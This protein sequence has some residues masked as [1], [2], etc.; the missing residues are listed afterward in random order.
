MYVR[1]VNFLSKLQWH[2]IKFRKI[3]WEIRD[4]K[5]SGSYDDADGKED[6][7]DRGEGRKEGRKERQKESKMNGKITVSK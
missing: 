6:R 3:S 2:C 5:G 4:R 1:N 7:G